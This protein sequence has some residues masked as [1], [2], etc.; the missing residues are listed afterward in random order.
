M[1]ACQWT[2]EIQYGRK[3]EALAIIRSWGAEKFRSS[4]F[5]RSTNRIY[6]GF[7]GASSSCIVDEYVFQNLA[8]FEEALADMG[9]PQFQA[10]SDALA[11]LVV[12]GTQ[13]WTIF[14][15]QS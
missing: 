6:S 7:I 12:P 5:K 11:P 8:D 10:F 15:I 3:K 13:K 1:Y 9:Q 2:I 14:R 4:A